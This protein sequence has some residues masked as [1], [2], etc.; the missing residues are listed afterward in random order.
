MQIVASPF[1]LL[2]IRVIVTSQTSK[3][4]SIVKFAMQG[5]KAKELC[6]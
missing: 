6:N 2:A 5:V 1:Y 4:E 3:Q